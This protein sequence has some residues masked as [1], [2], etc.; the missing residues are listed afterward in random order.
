MEGNGCYLLQHTLETFACKYLEKPRN[1]LSRMTN[2][3]AGIET[4]DFPN[5]K[6]KCIP[7]T[8]YWRSRK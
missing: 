2:L 3:R 8:R 7:T 5:K 6:Q 1:P 4:Q